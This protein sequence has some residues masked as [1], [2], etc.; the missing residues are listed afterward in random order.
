MIAMNKNKREKGQKHWWKGG[1]CILEGVVKKD[2]LQDV[3]FDQ[4]PAL[5]EGQPMVIFKEKSSGQGCWG[6]N[7]TGIQEAPQAIWLL[8]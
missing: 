2:Y 4:R 6:R 5:N 8:E 1:K 3:L 7:Q